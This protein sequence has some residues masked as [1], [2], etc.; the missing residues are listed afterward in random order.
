MEGSKHAIACIRCAERKVKCNRQHPC[1]ACTIHKVECVFRSR[2]PAKK[3]QKTQKYEENLERMKRFEAL[4]LDKGIDPSKIEA[5]AQASAQPPPASGQSDLSTRYQQ[6]M[7][8]DRSGG[9]EM[10]NKPSILQGQDGTKL[11]DK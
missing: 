9:L 10:T 6:I 5:A 11:I 3:K 2:K 8:A 1:N 7:M 4:L